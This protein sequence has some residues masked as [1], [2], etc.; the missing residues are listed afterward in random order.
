Y[1]PTS[2][3]QLWSVTGTTKATVGTMVFDGDVVF[4]SG[5]YPGKETLGIRADGSE[6]VVWRNNQKSYVPS[7]LVYDGYVYQISDDGRAFCW[8]ADTGEEQWRARLGGNYS[9]SPIL[10]GETI[11]VP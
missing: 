2:G 6:Q 4:A 7:L 8:K 5:G 3:E 11:Y 1:D 10:A 9:A